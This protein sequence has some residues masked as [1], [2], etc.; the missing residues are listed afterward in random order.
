[1]KKDITNSVSAKLPAKIVH[2]Q[3]V[4]FRYRSSTGKLRKIYTLFL[5]IT[6]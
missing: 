5:N 4:H 3:S 2:R 1:M 6:E